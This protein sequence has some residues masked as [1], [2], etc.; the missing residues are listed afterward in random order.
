MKL[1]LNARR[2]VIF[3]GMIY[4]CSL[5]MSHG[6]YYPML[7][8]CALPRSLLFVHSYSYSSSVVVFSRVIAR[9]VALTV[10]MASMVDDE[11]WQWQ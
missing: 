11:D 4:R 3:Y 8:V 7:L 5:A 6:L 1:K 10:S 9:K 2:S